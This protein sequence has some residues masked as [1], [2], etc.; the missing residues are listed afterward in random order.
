MFNF[1]AE[2]ERIRNKNMSSLVRSDFPSGI[3]SYILMDKDGDILTEEVG[4]VC[5][6]RMK[7]SLD[8]A[9]KV[10]VI[11]N[12]PHFRKEDEK[13]HKEIYHWLANESIVKDVF[14]T[15]DPDVM[16]SA[17]M[18]INPESPRDVLFFALTYGRTFFEDGWRLGTY[19][20]LRAKGVSVREAAYLS[21]MFT[22]DGGFFRYAPSVGN[23]SPFDGYYISRYKD[24][25]N[26]PLQPTQGKYVEGGDGR[27]GVF[28]LFPNK[29][30]KT[31]KEVF[32]MEQKLIKKGWGDAARVYGFSSV[33][34]L[35]SEWKRVTK[36]GK[37][38]KGKA[39][40][41]GKHPPLIAAICVKNG[42]TLGEVRS[43]RK[44]LYALNIPENRLNKPL[45][46]A[47][48]WGDTPQGYMYWQ[49]IHIRLKEVGGYEW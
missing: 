1:I 26:G 49:N 8:K 28:A 42:F 23:H 32:V 33:D 24:F 45:D 5:Y 44:N 9:S 41:K 6:A 38:A 18:L 43:I 37:G 14:L 10:A 22:E 27:M 12:F 25:S 46:S 34:K 21:L 16:F 29:V 36:E 3:C 30:G 19:R 15:K 40:R 2:V 20:S 35:I 4:D 11:L 7:L 17:G 48:T 13:E 47:F 39:V 31:F